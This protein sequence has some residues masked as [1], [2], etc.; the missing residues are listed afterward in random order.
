MFKKLL[1]IV[2]VFVTYVVNSQTV[3]WVGGSGYWSDATHWAQKSG[4]APSNLLPNKNTHVIFDNLSGAKDFSVH[5]LTNVEVNSITSL[6]QRHI[7]TLIG[8]PNVNLTLNG[9]LA[10]NPY[11][12]IKHNGKIIL[13]PSQQAFYEFSHNNLDN[14]VVVNS[15][16]EVNLSVLKTFK[17]VTLNGNLTLKN[18]Y[19]ICDKLFFGNGIVNLLNTNLQANQTVK[20]QSASV[21]VLSPSFLVTPIENQTDFNKTE[22]LKL[23]PLIA[24]TPTLTATTPKC[25]AICDGV[26]IVNISSCANGPFTITIP[27]KCATPGVT[28]IAVAAGTYTFNGICGC[29]SQYV[30]NIRNSLN[31]IGV[32]TISIADPPL[33]DLIFTTIEPTC[34]GLCD[35]MII[36]E[37]NLPTAAPLSAQYSTGALHTGI[38]INIPDTLKNLCAGFYDV[39]TTNANGCQESFTKNLTQPNPLTLSSITTSATCFGVCN[40][41]ASV[42]ASGG[43]GGYTYSWSPTSAP[44]PTTTFVNTLCAGTFTVLVTDTKSCTATT[45]KT[46]TQ[47]PIIAVAIVTKSLTCFNICNGSATLTTTG[48]KAPYTYTLNPGAITTTSVITNLCSG[49]YTVDVKD[50]QQCVKQV[51]FQ[52]N[53]PPLLT[54][55]ITTKDVD[56]N[57]FCNGSAT[58]T[59]TGGSPI[60]SY[61]WTGTNPI[62]PVTSTLT[63]ANGLCS[64]VYSQTV[65]DA[66]G[67]VSLNTFTINQPLPISLTLTKTDLKCNGVCDGTATA[68]V[69]GGTGSAYTYTWLP[70]NPAGQGTASVTGLCAGNYS[71]TIKDINSCPKN[72]TF[73]ITEPPPINLNVTFANIKCNSVCSGSIGATPSGGTGPYVISLVSTTG[74]NVAAPPYINLCA[75]TYTVRLTDS[76]GCLKTQTVTITQPNLLTLALTTTTLNC[77]GACNG[78]ASAVINGGTATYT[79]SWSNGITNSLTVNNLCAGLITATVT[80]VNTCTATANASLTAPPPI[81]ITVNVTQPKCAGQ[82]NG[83]V[84]A[85]IAG[86]T[87]NY[88]VTWSNGASGTTNSNLCAG[89][90]TV[91]VRDTKGCTTQTIATLVAPPTI[92][93]ATT[94]G[95][96]SCSGVCDA[97]LSVIATGGTSPFTYG[98]S[99][100][101]SHTNAVT[102][103]ALCQGNYI[104]N[105]TDANGCVKSA[106]ASVTQPPVLTATIN[107]VV[108]SCNI[109]IGSATGQ[110]L[111][112]TAPYTYSW[113]T[114]NQTTQTATALCVGGHTVFVTDNKG[115]VATKTVTILQAVTILITANGNTLACN[116]SCSGIATA[117][118]SG[119][120][121]PYTFTWSPTAPTQTTQTATN[122]CAGIN[123]TVKAVDSQGCSNTQ[124]V[125][126]NNPPSIVLTVVPTSV[127]CNAACN[128][129]ATVNA[130]GGTGTVTFSWSTG[131]TG[132]SI[133]NL[134]VGSYTVIGTDANGCKQQQVFNITEPT[135]LTVSFTTN[136]PATCVSSDGSITYTV[137]GGTP[138]YAT[139]PSSPQNNLPDGVYTFTITDANGCKQL[140]TTTLIDPAGPTV[141][142]ATTSIT[143]FGLC[144]GATTITANGVAPISITLPPLPTITN[145][146]LTTNGLCAGNYNAQVLDGNGCTTNQTITIVEPP[147]Y[148]ITGVASTIKCNAICNGSVNLTVL[149]GTPNYNY[150]WSPTGGN[151]QDPAGLCAGNYTVNITDANNCPTSQTFAITQ[152][153]TV[154]VMFNKQD[155]L[156]NGGFTGAVGVNVFGGTAPF[157]YSWAPLPPFVGSTLDTIINLGVGIYTVTVTD[158]NACSVTTTINIDEPTALTT[159][160]T[161]KN[162][163]CAGMCNGGALTLASGGIAPYS[164]NPSAS[165]TNLCIGTYSSVVTDANGCINSKIFTVTQPLPLVINA[166][167]IDPTCNNICNG[168]I[169]TTVSGGNPNY[170]YSWITSGQ[171]VANPTGLCAG[172]HTVI[173]TDDSLCTGQAIVTLNNPLAL[174][175][176]VTFTNP[177]CSGACNG[178]ATANPINN[179]GTVTYSWTSPLQTNQ[180]A[181]GLCPTG[182]SL[183]ITD[184]NGCIANQ[185]ISLTAPTPLNVNPAV[186]PATCT[187]SNGTINASNVTGGLA[188]YTYNWSPPVTP[189]TN[190]V[191]TGLASGV[192]T[193]IVTD[194]LGCSS[195]VFIPLSNSDGPSGATITTTSITCV[196]QCNGSASISNPIGGTPG[197]TLSWV[198]PNLPN[199]ILNLCV[200]TYTAEI[201]DA[202]DCKLYLAT[203]VTEP[204]PID[205]NEIITSATC[206]GNCNGSVALNPTGGN[207]VYTY[208]WSTTVATGTVIGLCPGPLSATITDANNCMFTATYSVASL[209]SITANTFVVNNNCFND[210]S[211]S[212]LVTNIAGGVPPYLFV[213]NDVASQT[214][215]QAINL[216]ASSYTVK[217]TDANGCFNELPATVTAP[218]QLTITPTVTQPSCGL[219]NGLYAVVA[220]GGTPNY[221]ILTSPVPPTN[222]FAGI[223]PVSVTDS[224]GCLTNTNIIVNNSTGITGEVITK[225]DVTCA[226]VCNGTISIAAIGGAPVVTYSWTD[227]GATTQVRTGLCAG[228]YFCNMQD[229]NGCIRTASVTINTATTLTLTPLIAQTSCTANTGSIN[230]I[231]TGGTATYNYLWIPVA[232]NT[233]SLTSLSAGNYS[234][235]VTDGNG[236]S[237]SDVFSISS[238]NSPLVT[239]TVSN[240]TCAGLN[241][242]AINITITGGTPNYTTSWSNGAVTEDVLG[243]LA[244]AYSYTVTDFAGCKAVNQ[245]SLTQPNPLLFSAP[246]FKF[247]SCNNICDGSITALPFGGTLPFTYSW[248]PTTNTTLIAINL[249]VGNYTLSVLD[250]NSCATTTSYSLTGPPAIVITATVTD[251]NCFGDLNGA[252]TATAIGGSGSL[253]YSWSTGSTTTN[254][255][256]GLPASNYTL[257]VFDTGGCSKD[258]VFTVKQPIALTQTNT[259]VSAQCFGNCNGSINVTAN[260]GNGGFIYLWSPSVPSVTNSVSNI[261][262]GNYSLTITDNKGCFIQPNFNVPSIVTITTAITFTNNNCFNQSN[263]SLE[264]T[265][266]GGGA[267]GYTFLWND[268]LGTIGTVLSNQP[269]G[270]YSIT[271]TDTDGCFNK[272]PGTITSPSSVSVTPTTNNPSCGMCNGTATLN[273]SGGT[274]T[275]NVNWT[276]AAQTGTTGT[277][278]CAGIYGL[279]ITDAN[280]CITNTNIIINSS[281]GITGETILTTDETCVG[282]CNGTATLT[283]IGGQPTVTY[284]WLHGPTSQTL[285]NLCSGTYTCNMVDANNCVRTATIGINAATTLTVNSQ[286]HQTGCGVNTGSIEVT[287]TGGTNNYNYNWM[288]ASLGTGTLVVNLAPGVYTLIVT[289]ASGCSKTEFYTI[290]SINGPI[291]TSTITNESCITKCDGI[292]DISITGGNPSYTVNWSNGASATLQLANVCAGNYSV[293]VTDAANCST[294]RNFSIT[295]N[296][297]IAFSAPT[298]ISPKCNN[299]C[300]GSLNI[301]PINGNPAFTYVWNPVASNS[302]TL[303]GLCANIYSVLVTDTKGCSA[304][305]SFTLVNPSK[306]TVAATITNASCSSVADGAIDMTING[307]TPPNTFAWTPNVAITE[308]LTNVLFGPYT[309][310]VTDANGCAKDTALQINANVVVIAVAGNDTSFCQNGTA[311]LNGSNST[312][313]VTYQ[314]FNLPNPIA[315]SNNLITTATPTIGLNTYVLVATNGLCID[316]DSINVTSNTLPVVDAG[317]SV[318]IPLGAT[319][320][321]GGSPTSAAATSFTW[322][323][324]FTL[325]D[326]SISN[327]VAITT[328]TTVYTVSITDANGCTNSDSMTVNIY[329]KIIIPNGFSPNADGKND[330]WMIDYI[331]L[332]P[333]NEVEVYNR[334]GEQ[335]FYSKGYPTPWNGLYKNKELPV[336]TYYYIINLNHPEYPE[337]YTGPLTIFR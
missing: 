7:T 285:S 98:W 25:A 154:T 324:S 240:I 37:A 10:L 90:Y 214:N 101:L 139:S 16:Y 163:T 274:P 248:T 70:G 150:T 111:G 227:N 159:T 165:I 17:S 330:T 281:S 31:Q 202:N 62:V 174:L 91:F 253:S 243:L 2:S 322:L 263:G 81:T 77:S 225:K 100:S 67:C 109:C 192:Y 59:A 280:N 161:I 86:G 134:C 41:S 160:I 255:I 60:Y 333:D 319:I 170:N 234:L 103:S 22:G 284:N 72:T 149:G 219:N 117:N 264:A 24:C 36:L 9:N 318:S 56:C 94:N 308:D 66:K 157:T 75:G 68:S 212:A 223:Y 293:L 132:N 272:W 334:W 95:T 54:S 116:N 327:P 323:P 217:V 230:V 27:P 270:T 11:F 40:G 229:A 291:V 38:G 87:P 203:T 233:Q 35:G 74:T 76:Q 26:L 210:C 172:S 177:T 314:W 250:A 321:V 85:V 93:L 30:V 209:T 147:Q 197:Y 265:N 247:P 315:I 221:T 79:V 120:T 46:I 12:K 316:V 6:S 304:T 309:F 108:P 51:T 84:T 152:P 169:T 331:N 125:S 311:L 320:T 88:T 166:T 232:P 183:Q 180:T 123:Y 19:I 168:S 279:L 58:V 65:T 252:I 195:T 296:P 45:T 328:I 278:L 237:L 121:T 182:Y 215:A 28:L 23:N 136:N 104:V 176:N 13:S 119:G 266:V 5:A 268:A 39:T 236:C 33:S 32:T 188:P 164:F 83:I 313:G 110:G 312:G 146:I 306:I 204:Q 193:V 294:V 260:G 216:C 303:S 131:A 301:L 122:L 156:C 292:I 299:D 127:T 158:A 29:A 302:P 271:I 118:A 55:S 269:N 48:G 42:T 178:V 275:Y 208:S 222:L 194:A 244:G 142:V 53:S 148:T 167:P 213:W 57:G 262:P 295:T 4:G 82:C 241:N 211:G 242:G 92:T 129:S 34:F 8:S 105:V 290:N 231:A 326:A 52:I 251:A 73:T 64:G 235:T 155:V 257:T 196:G 277:G 140:F 249:C 273:L 97:S 329:P 201:K 198:N 114:T 239:N 3:Y 175:A 218:T 276:S 141:T 96:M 261:C 287:V 69:T 18:T 107:N 71:L 185:T 115:C 238:I 128:G 245:F 220:I 173:V 256:T 207:G 282:L 137:S 89:V 44:S 228:T 63:I 126:F 151:N 332:F 184:G 335:L 179:V 337:P 15:N 298:A 20:A 200:G 78:S 49:T 124:T 14:D 189:S 113:S 143:C 317:P 191:V 288:P 259:I 190:T 1:L 99:S 246:V 224:K 61:T 258:T 199:P 135:P 144:N 21:V 47:P 267:G 171:T 336:G 283:A 162:V 153:S 133:A 297:A 254:S 80:D 205:D 181:T 106:A 50:A 286:V 310:T 43:N 145:T 300:N 130:T 289:D 186:I 226:G 325:S 102:P 187:F 305:Q 206:F 138:V 112:G 307:G